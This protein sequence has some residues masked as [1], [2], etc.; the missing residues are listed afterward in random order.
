MLAGT[1]SARSFEG[2]AD[3]ATASVLFQLSLTASVLQYLR[4]SPGQGGTF[5]FREFY[6]GLD[7]RPGRKPWIFVPRREDRFE[8]MKPLMAC[9]LECAAT[10]ILGLE[11][12]STRRVW[13]MLDELPDMPRVENLKRLLPQGRKFGAAAVL[14]FQA[15]GQMRD[16]YGKDGAEAL[17][18]CA[19]TKLFLQ[20]VDAD[21]RKWASQCIGEAEVEVRGASESLTL[22]IGK[23]RTSLGSQRQ[24][25]PP[26]WRA[27][28]DFLGSTVSCSYLTPFQR[29]GSSWRTTTSLPGGP[30]AAWLC[31]GRHERDPSGEFDQ[32]RGR[33]EHLRRKAL[34][35]PFS[36]RE[37]Q[38]DGRQHFGLSSAGQASSYYEADD[39]WSE[40]GNAPSA[41]LG[42]GAAALGL[43]GPVNQDQFRSL[44]EGVLPSGQTLGRARDGELEHRP[45][46]DL[47]L[48]APKS[49]SVAALVAGD[50]RLIE[51]HDRA[52]AVAHGFAERHGASTRVRTDGRVET[53][54]TGKFII[55]SFRHRLNREFSAQLHAHGVTIN[56]TL[57]GDGK[58]RSLEARNH[59]RDPAQ[60][61]RGLSAG[62]GFAGPS[63]RLTRCDLA[64]GSHFE[65]KGVPE[66]ALKAFSER[67][68]QVEAAL[69]ERGKTRET[70][71]AREK[72]SPPWRPGIAS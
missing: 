61:R 16:T 31:A 62:I 36:P 63:P 26:S 44:L 46:W 29:P 53:E 27:N 18:G 71:S 58:W 37:G 65:I 4:K 49:V 68:G 30:E 55:A 6:S 60:G 57:D 48:S 20:L 2:D 1:S 21:S 40:A 45:G 24:T 50:T 41:W 69:A 8:A 34:I 14:T 32:G 13:L 12:S 43:S 19:N 39:Y 25:S 15:I 10:A 56:A 52:A 64:K 70:A 5:S 51:A 11:P 42:E 3:K 35:H 23:G 9:W 66:A 54:R 72:K 38:S 59:L 67:S 22:E 28:S 7:S 47:T 33:S 17:L